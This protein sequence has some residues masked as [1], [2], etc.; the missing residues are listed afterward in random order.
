MKM[1]MKNSHSI[2]S[3][4]FPSLRQQKKLRKLA[5]RKPSQEVKVQLLVKKMTW[6]KR[7]KTRK[8]NRV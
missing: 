2:R 1:H 5:K 6:K 7:K 8:V 3:L 4:R